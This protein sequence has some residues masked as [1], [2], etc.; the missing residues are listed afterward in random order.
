LLHTTVYQNL[1]YPLKI[2]NYTI[3]EEQVDY[4]LARAGLTDKKKQYARSLSSGEQQKLSFIRALI[5]KPKLVIIDETLSNLDPDSA[6]L[7]EQLILEQQNKEPITWITISH[8]LVHIKKI[9]D[10]VHFM[11]N[12]NIVARGTPQQMLLDPV[13]P[14]VIKYLSNTEVSFKK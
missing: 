6:A 12:G 11:E 9:C 7:F 8:Q 1:I 2:R 5:F 10:I 14:S 4:W 3:E 13:H